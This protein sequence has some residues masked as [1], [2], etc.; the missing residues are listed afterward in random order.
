MAQAQEP[1]D[2]VINALIRLRESKKFQLAALTNNFHV[3]GAPPPSTVRYAG[4]VN[5][6]T[7]RA[8]LADTTRAPDA[9]GAP[10]DMM[11]SMF[12]IYVESAVEGVR[13]VMSHSTVEVHEQ[14]QEN[15]N[16][17]RR[18]ETESDILS[19]SAGST[20]NQGRRGYLPRRYRNQLGRR[21]EARYL[22]NPC[23]LLLLSANSLPISCCDTGVNP[24]RSLE[25]LR[26]LQSVTGVSLLSGEDAK[27]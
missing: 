16:D 5:A 19:T 22:H 6:Q 23:V 25:A 1:D 3:P 11:K 4:L 13:Y 9:A 18:Q 24:G 7:I 2:R 26:E 8:S 12:D 17:C 10:S 14:E 20:R 21:E 15:A 27:L